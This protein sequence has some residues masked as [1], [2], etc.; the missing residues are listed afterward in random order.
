MLLAATVLIAEILVDESQPEAFI[1]PSL[2]LKKVELHIVKVGEE[3]KLLWQRS[4]THYALPD[5]AGIRGTQWIE[6]NLLVTLSPD[7][8]RLFIPSVRLQSG[9]IE[10]GG[11][12]LSSS[13]K[14]VDTPNFKVPDQDQLIFYYGWNG[15]HPAI[16]S[17]DRDGKR[18]TYSNLTG[19]WKES[20]TTPKSL[21]SMEKPNSFLGLQVTGNIM[22]SDSWQCS[23]TPRSYRCLPDYLYLGCRGSRVAAT[24]Q[25]N[26][27]LI[28][29]GKVFSSDSFTEVENMIPLPG[30]R[31]IGRILKS[32]KPRDIFD[33]LWADPTD[34][35]I[36]SEVYIFDLVRG[37]KR[38]LGKGLFGLPVSAKWLKSR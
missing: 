16:V 31:G 6:S 21:L 34:P 26:I 3:P 4:V 19:Q 23:M 11:T 12:I 37:T 8:D 5:D 14:V 10:L 18:T 30:G 25:K 33:G 35:F 28:D 24:L 32:L 13:G 9:W 27:T 7:N 22:F 1:L 17:E 29:N 2:G 20:D 38:F 36:D 15:A